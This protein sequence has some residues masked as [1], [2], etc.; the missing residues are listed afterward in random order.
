MCYFGKMR[1]ST[2]W[3]LVISVGILALTSRSS[4]V[5]QKTQ[6]TEKDVLQ[7]MERCSQCHGEAQ[8]GG[9][10]LRTRV[11][12]LAGGNSGPAIVPGHADQSLLIKRVSGE[13]KPQMP[14][15]SATPNWT[16][17]DIQLP[18]ILDQTTFSLDDVT[19]PDAAFIHGRI[20]DAGG[21]PVVGGELRVFQVIT[22]LSLCGQVAHAPDVCVIPAQLRGHGTSDDLG[23]V[24][25]TVPR[26]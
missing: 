11:G 19:I 23:I 12:M 24:R 22:D 10:D 5:A 13:V 3:L 20:T 4:L 15:G 7:I 1:S 21:T 2:Y 18:R 8:V 14:M 26:N 6:A 16:K 25:F 9:L 17:A